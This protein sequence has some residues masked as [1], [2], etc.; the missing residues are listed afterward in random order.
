MSR[1][2]DTLERS[3]LPARMEQWEHTVGR[4]KR[5]LRDDIEARGGRTADHTFAPKVE[6]YAPK[7]WPHTLCTPLTIHAAPP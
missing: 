4:Q 7:P 2:M 5:Q 1:S 6:R 3:R